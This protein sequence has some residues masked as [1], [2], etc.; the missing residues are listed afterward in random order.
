[1]AGMSKDAAPAD[2]PDSAA[3]QLAQRLLDAQ[4]EW[5]V[6]ELSGKRFTAMVN[7]DIAD[8]V[9]VGSTLVL[10][11]I[12]DAGTVKATARRLVDVIGGSAVVADMG[13][14]VADALYDLSASDEQILGEVV[15]RESV[16]ALIAKLISMH[17]LQDRAMERLTESPL[18]AS[19][20]TRYVTKLVGDFVQQNRERAEKVPGVSSLLSLGLGAASK[21]RGATDQFLGDAQARGT[22]F[23]MRRSNSAMREMIREAPLHEAAMEVWDL[24]AEEP[25]SALREYLTAQD[26][27]ELLA[28]VHDLLTTAR[29]HDYVG[30]IVDECI[31]VF[32]AKYGSLDVISLL[33]ELG[34]DRALL[35]D[36]IIA[37]APPVIKM[38]KADGRLDALVRARFE[39]FFTSEATL[40]VLAGTAVRRPKPP[41][42]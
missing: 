40:A 11:D 22:Q 2:G 42:K 6:A 20:A 9:D 19:I 25:I 8:F 12:V 15:D 1:M 18:V 14:A 27:R 4:V 33:A 32:F 36:E 26:L 28:I 39:P 35:V 38:L 34:I 10:G 21:V 17:Q 37:F 23:A 13:P 3:H 41:K 5:I 24:Q 31:D 7:R 30:L 16:D 29:T